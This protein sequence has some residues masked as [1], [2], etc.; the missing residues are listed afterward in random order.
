MMSFIVTHVLWGWACGGTWYSSASAGKTSA[1]TEG[2]E[3]LYWK[4]KLGG[5]GNGVQGRTPVC[6][7][8][9]GLE[10]GIAFGVTSI[11]QGTQWEISLRLRIGGDVAG[12][13]RNSGGI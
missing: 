8:V 3:V 11:S 10:L 1:L 9:N 12:W 5:V 4:A 13:L 7:P 6:V 2:G